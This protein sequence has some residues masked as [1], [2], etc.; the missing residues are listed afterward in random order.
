MLRAFTH[1]AEY[2][3]TG[4]TTCDRSWNIPCRHGIDW[5]NLRGALPILMKG[6]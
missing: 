2:C 6:V 1:F 5:P 4:A 3:I